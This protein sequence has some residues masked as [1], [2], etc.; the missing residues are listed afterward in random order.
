MAKLFDRAL[1]TKYAVSVE[2]VHSL[3][4][5]IPHFRLPK[6]VI[7]SAGIEAPHMYFAAPTKSFQKE[8]LDKIRTLAPNFFD[9][10]GETMTATRKLSPIGG[11]VVSQKGSTP[12][13]LFAYIGRQNDKFL[14]G[15]SR[16]SPSVATI[17]G[18]DNKTLGSVVKLHEG[19]EAELMK[20]KNK[21]LR[22]LPFQMATGHIGLPVI[23]KE[24]NLLTTLTGD[25]SAA[26]VRNLFHFA[27]KPGGM[28]EDLVRKIIGKGYKHGKSPRLSRHAIKRI[29]E[30]FKRLNPDA[31]FMKRIDDNLKF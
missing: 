1:L 18:R 19:F 7:Q 31:E 2:K 11:V 22:S 16:L 12:K 4:K 5:K 29:T 23:L 8:H 13:K 15:D 25:A 26:K 9:L 21:K 14:F 30:S 3:A 27:R 28:E 6:S 20:P 17:K 24:H 10:V